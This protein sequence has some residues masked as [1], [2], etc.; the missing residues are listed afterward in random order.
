MALE[1]RDGVSAFL[2][3][4]VSADQASRRG[5]LTKKLVFFAE[6]LRRR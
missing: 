2:E 4:P 1:C 6:L 3:D 5:R